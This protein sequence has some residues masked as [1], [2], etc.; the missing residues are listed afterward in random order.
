MGKVPLMGKVYLVGAGPGNEDLITIKGIK[1]LEQCDVVIY[2]RLV[3]D[4]L[5]NHVKK[6]CKKVY[7]GKASGNHSMSQEEINQVLIK[8]AKAYPLVVRLK[9][10]DPFVFG[11]GGEE[12]EELINHRIPF[13]VVPGVTSAIAVPSSVGI[14]VTQ[15]GISQSFHVIT[16]HT[17]A[18]KDM[19]LKQYELLAKLEGTLIFLMGLSSIEKIVFHLMQYGKSE[20]TPV[21][22][23]S[24]G[25]TEKEKTV[26]GTLA[27]IV[28]LVKKE[29][30]S[31]PGIIIVGDT[32]KLNY[33]SISKTNNRARIGLTGT[34]AMRMKLRKKLEDEGYQVIDVCDMKIVEVPQS[35]ELRECLNNIESYNWIL[36]TSQNAIRLF[37]SIIKEASIDHRRLSKIK[38]AVIGSGSKEELEKYGYYA[39]FMPDKYTTDDLAHKFSKI[40]EENEKVL[41]PRAIQGSKELTSIFSKNKINFK[42]VLFYDVV[43]K[44]CEET[45]LN[46]DINYIDCFVFASASGVNEFFKEISKN[47]HKLSSHTK[48]VCIGKVTAQAV[49]KLDRQ[50]DMIGNVCDTDGIVSKLNETF[51]G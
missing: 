31:S 51:G 24:N 27:S 13:E 6:D 49:N 38:F 17:M 10:G 33:R 40:V 8:Y 46:D 44:L 39:D 43:G 36:F 47:N 7:V 29:Q 19:D 11:R 9:G 37:F 45:I 41:I 28:E 30:L 4:K 1:L 26:R 42:E 14:P 32:A 16:G 50:V 35:N 23:V 5:F 15:R 48:I 18:G 21:A 2:D 12:V 34:E 20:D 22:V 3:S 25:T